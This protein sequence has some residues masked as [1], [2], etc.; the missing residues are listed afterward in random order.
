VT[1]ASGKDRYAVILAG[2]DGTRLKSLTRMISGDDRPKQFCAFQGSTT[3]LDQTRQRIALSVPNKYTLTVVTQT[4]ERFYK[5]LFKNSAKS[6]LLVQPI[7]KGTAPAILLSA[8]KVAQLSPTATV[9]FFPSDHHLTNEPQ[10]M[11][12]VENAFAAVHPVKETITLLGI[13][14]DKPEISYGWIEPD[15]ALDRTTSQ[16]SR[17]KRFWEKPSSG[18]ARRLMQRGGLWN[19]FV[20]VGSVS[21]FLKIIERTLPELY[22]LFQKMASAFGTAEEATTLSHAYSSILH[23]TFQNKSCRSPP[24]TYA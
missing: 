19:S 16:L 18:V 6:Q 22:R 20:M 4:H 14:P 1:I 17:V 10:F 13:K 11:E 2:G 21:A 23:Q 5:P 12:H 24:T 15:G 9:A 8:L 7:N 3:L